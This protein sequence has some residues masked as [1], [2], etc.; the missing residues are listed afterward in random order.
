MAEIEEILQHAMEGYA[1][2]GLN[3]H[4]YLTRT[5]DGSLFTVIY[6]GQVRDRTVVDTGLVARIEGEN[7]ILERD[8]N[9]KPLVDALVQAGV[10]REQIVLAYAGERVETA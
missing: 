3:G 8:T 5:Q 4:G 2:E 7:I 9:N 10:P 6:I 1:V